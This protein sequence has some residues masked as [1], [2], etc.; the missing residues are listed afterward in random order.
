[1]KNPKTDFL[2][3]VNEWRF[4]DISDIESKYNLARDHEH[5][6]TSIRLPEFKFPNNWFEYT[7]ENKIKWL[8][9]K[10]RKDRGQYG[11]ECVNNDISRLSKESS[12]EFFDSLLKSNLGLE[13]RSNLLLRSETF[14][15]K[16][17]LHDNLSRNS[18]ILDN[19][20]LMA[21]VKDAEDVHVL[22][23]LFFNWIYAD[24]KSDWNNRDFILN[25]RFNENG[26]NP[27][28]EGFIGASLLKFP[29]IGA[30]KQIK[31]LT[32]QFYDP[33]ENWNYGIK[34]INK[35]F[36]D[37]NLYASEGVLNL[38][39]SEVSDSLKVKIYNLLGQQILS[40]EI[41]SGVNNSYLVDGTTGYYLV[42][43]IAHRKSKTVKV[44]MP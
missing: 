9:D 32:I 25:T 15:I 13:S 10:E 8:V 28:A 39:V 40:E 31:V 26:G 37:F 4:D 23:M 22:E 27:Y 14:V 34:E 2:Y 20:Q 11:L 33:G 41:E 3:E 30:E 38:K 17:K 42:K 7:P 18:E 1:M 43:I 16:G 5:I 29:V 19:N 36:I 21:I 6:E 24:S 35:D 12:R 44:Y